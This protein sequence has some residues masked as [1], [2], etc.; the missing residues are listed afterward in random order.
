MIK[1]TNTLI[2][3]TGKDS[4]KFLQ[5][6]VT[7][8]INLLT[9]NL[10]NTIYSLILTPKGRYLF[11]IFIYQINNESFLLEVEEQD[12]NF[13][14]ETLKKYTLL[15]K[16]TFS[17]KENLNSY[18]IIPTINN[19]S[20]QENIIQDTRTNNLGHKIITEKQLPATDS[21][22]N[23]LTYLYNQGIPTSTILIK[24]KTIPIEV[25]FDELNAICYKKGCYLG[26]EFTNS[27]KRKLA[28]KKRLLQATTSNYNNI[29]IKDEIINNNQEKIGEIIYINKDT[30]TI[31]ILG[32]IK[33]LD[34]QNLSIN[35]QKITLVKPTH[36]T[37][38]TLE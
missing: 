22:Q 23:Y 35:N 19:N 17:L 38:F 5:G 6:L 12:A 3:V 29:Q 37:H 16:I 15:S 13:L 33:F 2:E 4:F 21:Y 26:Q 7:N 32:L 34:S 8:D 24:E 20:Y 27:A 1:L 9:S 25:G 10:S 30:K 14:L 28:I 11:D 36:T 18:Y 31:L